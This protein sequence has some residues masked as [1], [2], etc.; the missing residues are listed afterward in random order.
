MR[1][2]K[3]NH[4]NEFLQ[5][6]EK[7]KHDVWLTSPYGDKYNWKSALSQYIAIAAL[8]GNH[9]DELEL[10]C[11]NRSDEQFFFKFFNENPEVLDGVVVQR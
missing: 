4:V 6:I 9:G 8:L 5:A 11:D 1:I 2:K 7:C 10:F 3:I